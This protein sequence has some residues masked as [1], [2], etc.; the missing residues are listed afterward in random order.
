[1]K[2]AIPDRGSCRGDMVLVPSRAAV[3]TK[4]DTEGEKKKQ[5]QG[6]VQSQDRSEIQVRR[7][8]AGGAGNEA[9]HSRT[10]MRV[11]CLDNQQ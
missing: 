9:A 11:A 2:G 1:M 7:P 10:A 5:Y 8:I 4:N 3:G 6:R